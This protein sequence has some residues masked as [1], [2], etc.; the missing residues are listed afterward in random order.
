[1]DGIQQAVVQLVEQ[2]RK[3]PQGATSNQIN[4]LAR[5][6]NALQDL[7]SKWG[8]ERYGAGFTAGVEMNR[9]SG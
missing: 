8:Q 2:A 3:A 1:M 6:T 7:I 4:A 5:Q 9:R